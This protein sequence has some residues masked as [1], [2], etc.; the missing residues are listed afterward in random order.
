[1]IDINNFKNM[2]ELLKYHERCYNEYL[3]INYNVKLNKLISDKIDSKRKRELEIKKK[4]LEEVQ[5]LINEIITIDKTNIDCINRILKVVNENSKYKYNLQVISGMNNFQGIIKGKSYEDTKRGAWTFVVLAR[6]DLNINDI[7]LLEGQSPFIIFSEYINK[8]QIIIYDKLEGLD[9]IFDYL[10]EESN[11]KKFLSR[12]EK[13]GI[14]KD[15]ERK[16]C[17]DLFNEYTNRTTIKK[18]IKVK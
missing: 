3:N 15:G 4:R 9:I 2:I 16:L 12:K 13:T 18:K 6:E 7:T 8:N 11:L 17:E 14:S 10:K 5:E 1:M